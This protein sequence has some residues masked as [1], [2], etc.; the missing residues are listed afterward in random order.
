MLF[1]QSDYNFT[2]PLAVYKWYI[3]SAS[4]PALVVIV[5][6]AI[7]VGLLLYLVWFQFAFP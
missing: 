3:S 7:L 5:I 2:L 1:S 6:L 4:L